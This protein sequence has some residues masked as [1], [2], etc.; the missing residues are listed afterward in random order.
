MNQQ[1]IFNKFVA[2]AAEHFDM[3]I[4]EVKPESHFVDD[5]GCDSLD[6]V[7]ITMEAEKQFQTS[8]QDSEV[9]ELTTVQSLV[10]L[11]EKKLN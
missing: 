5:L 1:E 8:F 11:I 6:I 10:E 3:P 2:I 4:E 9:E 7:E